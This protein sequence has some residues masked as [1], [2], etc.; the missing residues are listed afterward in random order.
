MPTRDTDRPIR[1]LHLSDV[2][3]QA[4]KGWDADPV[5]RALARY[6]GEEVKAGL[7]PDLVV[8]TGDLAHAGTAE[9]YALARTWL[10]TQLWPA[11]PADLSRDRLAL[12][13]GN[14]DVDRSRV[15]R[16]ARLTQNGLLRGG[17]QD[18]I[19]D[20]LSNDDE[21]R[22]LLERH[23]AYL[24]FVAEW[25]GQPQA[26]PWWQRVIEVRGTRLHV[27]G[28][29]SAWMACGDE[30][31]G[32]L[33]L[34]RY[35]LTQTVE[36]QQADVHWRIALLHHPWDYL[37]EFDYRETAAV[38]QH[39]DLLLR[40][41]RHKTDPKRVVR[42][43]P[44]RSCLEL[45]AGCVYDNSEYPNAFQWIELSPVGKRV[46]V[47]FRAWV[48]HAWT[49]D[50]NRPG[51]RDG[52]WDVDL[53]EPPPPAASLV[54]RQPPEIPSDYLTWLRRQYASVELL[55]QDTQRGQAVTLSQVYVP[56]LT[57]AATAAAVQQEAE[58]ERFKETEE[59][60]LIPLLQRLNQASLYVSAPAG[61]GKSTF[62]RWAV[63]Q[64]IPG[65]AMSHPVAAP[66][67]FQ[68][69]V[70]TALHRR[71]PLLVPLRE[72]WMWMD[73]GRGCR[74][75]GRTDLEK[76]LAA[77]V[78]RS[79]PTCL[80]GALLKA[81]LGAGSAFLLLDG[82]D[83]VPV[84][85]ESRD[86][87]VYPWELLLSGLADAL[88]H[89]EKKGN[90]TLLTS[91]PYGLDEA[92]LDRLGLLQLAPLEPLPE[93]LQDLFV[94]RWF[95]T[96]DQPE[97]T[98]GLIQNIH[99]RDDL[100]P[101]AENPM[102]LT[103]LCVIY[104]S[105][106]R[107]PEDRYH[108]YRRI[109]DNVLYHRYPGAAHEREPVKARLEAI[110]LG[111]HTGGG[112]G[113]RQTP[114]AEVGQA[115]TER[116]LAAF[117]KLNPAY[118]NGRVQPA[119]Q[120]EDLLTHS[121]LLLPKPGGRAAFYHLSFQEFLAAER[122]ARTHDSPA[123]EQVFR[124][125]GAVPGWRT[126]LW[127]LFAAQ[128][129]NYRD[130]QWGLDLLQRLI[131]DQERPAVKV[132]PAPAVFIAEALELCLAKGYRVPDALAEG[133]RRLSLDAI[134]DEIQVQARQTLGLCLGR[135]G[136]PRIVGLRDPAAYVEVPA[137]TYPYGDEGDTVAIEMPFRL[138]RY[139]VTNGQYRAFFDDDGYGS[140]EW[141]SDAGWTWRQEEAVTE[142][143]WWRDRRWNAPNQPVVSVSF[144][145]AEACCAW[146]GGRL[147]REQEWEAA[148][149]GPEGFTYPWGN[150]WEDGICNTREVGLG[151]TSPV[152]LFPRSRPARLGL[153]DLAGNV[154]E[155]CG[156]LYQESD[157]IKGSNARRVLRGGSGGNQRVLA[158][159]AVR[160]R[161]NP[162]Y[163]KNVVGF[164][165]CG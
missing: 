19:A 81:H 105:G 140:R 14:H 91:R 110:A 117:A 49:V 40:G 3:L 46:R 68:E 118:E 154:W 10:D 8:I 119:I 131:A 79:P 122:I 116:L 152:G 149:R 165:V 103:A 161:R 139:P 147:P 15:G 146:A 120:R 77:F 144:W 158:R 60:R 6:I 89:W 35:Q 121:G 4:A 145:E 2:H 160:G 27:A 78:D 23:T 39:C 98:L 30:D 76:A 111:M 136:D 84:S 61:A 82:L 13:P 157:A 123:L 37:A 29:D 112:D 62:C 142:P 126:T 56:A 88:P 28:L 106:R 45:A 90:R 150:D 104:G 69:P 163:R 127:F 132:N 20:V 114:A 50:R 70:P 71:L 75:W 42:P 164:R 5:L 159:S 34:G 99:G 151:V 113:A 96:L 64:S 93:A 54:D 55:G 134:V 80:T 162:S 11:L 72:F 12:V 83:E 133:F 18:D 53:A 124:A 67:E 51:C 9:E 44:T 24:D 85:E 22:I 92:G 7:A 130:A 31:R 94:T 137:G 153:E 156:S 43:D 17:S 58:Q 141:W 41:H 87:T 86:G 135:L 143:E 48:E 59:R 155:W 73:C 129:F 97:L 128:V 101:L 36:P 47:R 32:R 63:L 26:L 115:E 100:A 74:I 95:H 38:Q 138:G 65:A 107:L 108:L 109:V 33:L 148:A 125:R 21:R 52:D 1:L 16:M 102:L 57:Q 66:E 25:L